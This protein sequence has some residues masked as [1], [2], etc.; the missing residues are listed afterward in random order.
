MV[1]EG[2]YKLRGVGQCIYNVILYIQAA[3]AFNRIKVAL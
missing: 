3:S 2:H 1:M